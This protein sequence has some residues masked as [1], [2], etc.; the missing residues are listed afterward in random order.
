M[1]TS[2]AD[3]ALLTEAFSGADVVLTAMG[4]TSTSSDGSGLLSAN[5]AAVEQS[6]LAAKVDR[7]L[8]INTMIASPPGEPADRVMRL[9]LLDA[10]H[11]GPR[12]C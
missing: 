7:I 1:V 11:D 10:R 9:L 2:L 8:M 5:M 3:R 6:M 4:V 12:G